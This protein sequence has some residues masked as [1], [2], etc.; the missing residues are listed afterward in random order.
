MGRV[1]KGMT[2]LEV[3]VALG[4]IG[5]MLVPLAN[6]MLTS[7]KA[8]KKAEDTQSGK[9]LGQQVVEKLKIKDRVESN[10]DIDFHNTKLKIKA[11]STNSEGKTEYPIVSEAEVNGMMIQGKV[12][13]EEGIVSVNDITYDSSTVLNKKVGLYLEL[14]RN[15]D[16]KIV[17][18]VLEGN[19]TL[20][21]LQGMIESTVPNK[22]K[23]VI[24]KDTLNLSVQVK[25]DGTVAVSS[26]DPQFV[27]NTAQKLEGAI[28]LYVKDVDTIS[29]GAGVLGKTV[30]VKVENLNENKF[31]ELQVL[32]DVD[33]SSEIW[34]AGLEVECKGKLTEH[35]NILY[36]EENKRRGLYTVELDI[37]KKDKV[38]ESTK[39]QFY[40]GE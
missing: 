5:I 39:A 14:D 40:L 26:I 7:V 16:D 9:L 35:K 29:G 15:E 23:Y 10:V 13:E 34:K 31:E 21:D 36:D 17:L 2:I 1:K 28:V 30:H 12:I 27:F 33:L 8:N 19:S 3:V 24:N 4:I 37:I 11:G 32:R 38:I 6:G 20:N 22:H 25:L 18:E